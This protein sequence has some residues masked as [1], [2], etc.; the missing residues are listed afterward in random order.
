MCR[1]AALANVRVPITDSGRVAAS[2]QSF[3]AAGGQNPMSADNAPLP[4]ILGWRPYATTMQETDQT[5]SKSCCRSREHR[6]F[7]RKKRRRA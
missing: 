3:M 5:D 1:Y 6:Q 7:V 4:V 2:G